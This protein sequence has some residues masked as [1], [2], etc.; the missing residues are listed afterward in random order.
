MTARR[1][2]ILA[3]A[4]IVVILAVSGI[5]YF[6]LPPPGGSTTVTIVVT[7]GPQLAPANFTVTEGQHVTIVF[8]N[9]DVGGPHEFEIPAL[10][11]STGVMQAGETVSVNF[12]PNRVGTFM[13][14]Q[15]CSQGGLGPCPPPEGYVTVLSP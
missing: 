6:M 7:A 10:G 3:A 13:V 8:E 4:A 15:P 14:V 1:T 5:Y 2:V 11:M 9:T 12:V